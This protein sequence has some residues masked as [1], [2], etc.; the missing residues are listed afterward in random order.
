MGAV[1]AAMRCM[2]HAGRAQL[3]QTHGAVGASPSLLHLSTCVGKN[4]MWE[5]QRSSALLERSWAVAKTFEK[6]SRCPCTCEAACVRLRNLRQGRTRQKNETDDGRGLEKMGGVGAW[7]GNG[8]AVRS[9]AGQ[10]LDGHTSVAVLEQLEPLGRT[11][12]CRR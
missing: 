8:L 11:C 5:Y 7:G 6:G 4:D 3:W 1:A 10:R 12:G 9:S 2:S